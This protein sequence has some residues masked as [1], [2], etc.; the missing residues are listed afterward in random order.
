MPSIGNQKIVKEI[1]QT[2]LFSS[3]DIEALLKEHAQK[4]C[5]LLSANAEIIFEDETEGSPPYKVGVKAR[6]EL[7]ASIK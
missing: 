6:V 2:V 5:S 1:R 3:K 7:I 4:V